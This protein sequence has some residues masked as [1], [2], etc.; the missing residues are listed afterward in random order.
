MF[1]VSLCGA[2][3]WVTEVNVGE[4]RFPLPAGRVG[5]GC[6]LPGETLFIPVVPSAAA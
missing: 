6:A 3:A 2:A 5:E 4:T 1:I